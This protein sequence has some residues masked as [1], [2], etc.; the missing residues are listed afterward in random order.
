M[1]D[2]R[3]LLLII[4]ILFSAINAFAQSVQED[5]V[6]YR[7]GYFY[8]G[9]QALDL[10]ADGNVYVVGYWEMDYLTL[11]YSP[12]GELLWDAR[13][14]NGPEIWDRATAIEVD[15]AGN[16]IVSG[17]SYD[18]EKQFGSY[19]TVKYDPDGKQLWVAVFADL[20]ADI[21]GLSGDCLALDDQDNVLVAG[22][23][24]HDG[25]FDYATIKYNAGGQHQWTRLYGSSVLGE[26]SPSDLAVDETGNVFVTGTS[27]GEDGLYDYATV[28]YD[29]DGNEQWRSRFDNN[30]DYWY[31]HSRLAV[32]PPAGV[33]V[34]GGDKWGPQYDDSDF[35][36]IKYRSDGEVAW[37]NTYSWSED[38]WHEFDYANA[39]AVD[40]DGNVFV[41]G[42]SADV[43]THDDF[44]TIKYGPDG[45]ELWTARFVGLGWSDWPTAITLD[46]RGDVYVTGMMEYWFST[47]KYESAGE[48][49]WSVVW[50]EPEGRYDAWV[51]GIRVDDEFNVYIQGQN[52]YT[53]L[54]TIKYSQSPPAALEPV[55]QSGLA[56]GARLGQNHP[57]PFNPDTVIEFELFH[58]AVVSL[59]IFDVRGRMLRTLVDDTRAAGRHRAVWDGNDSSGHESPSG[60]Y[61]YTLVT[62]SSFQTKSML[63][64]R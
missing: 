8:A 34:V 13:Y 54:T 19:V 30:I 11:K 35:V 6:R 33:V 52:N 31:H 47:V 48:E 62:E 4:L 7:S 42:A 9:H 46:D 2:Q 23:V 56:A 60:L 58:E 63:L 57:N 39:V 59:R 45:E 17:H 1:A 44:A 12:A 40:Q 24:K 20:D 14:G 32:C 38:E 3:K 5:W 53:G 18:F 41:T 37:T 15:S 22:K 26:D 50:Q 49:L 51:Y 55:A 64:L 27:Q 29:P 36:T 16:V 28:M 61:F 25:N 43:D 10:D 21:S